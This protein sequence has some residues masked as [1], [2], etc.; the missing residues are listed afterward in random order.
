MVNKIPC[1]GFFVGD[2]LEIDKATNTLKVTG[3]SS[4]TT[5]PDWNQNDETASDYIKN[6]PGG[7][8]MTHC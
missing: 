8:I 5:T 1:G 3:G 4:A 2:G 7:G 6:R